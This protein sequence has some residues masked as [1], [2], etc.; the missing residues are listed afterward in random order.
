MKVEDPRVGGASGKESAC[1]CRRRK[2]C[3]FD[4]WVG[5]TPKRRAWQPTPVFLPGESHRQRSLVGYGPYGLKESDMTDATKHA[6]TQG[7][8]TV[9]LNS[10][11]L[12]SFDDVDSL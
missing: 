4:L 12:S 6:Y 8:A 5:K 7:S 11:C 1:Q 3:G 10:C 9:L 2:R